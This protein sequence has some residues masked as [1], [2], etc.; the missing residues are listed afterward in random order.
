[1]D[2]TIQTDVGTTTS[3]ISM[4]ASCALVHPLT[5][6]ASIGVM[7]ITSNVCMTAQY[8]SLSAQMAAVQIGSNGIKPFRRPSG[9][10]SFA[11]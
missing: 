10:A 6:L 9:P 7:V 5:A 8:C 1:M 3:A 11:Q 2:A 4:M